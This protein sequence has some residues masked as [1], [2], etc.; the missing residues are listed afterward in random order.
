MK[1]QEKIGHEGV[2][3]VRK[4]IRDEN[5]VINAKNVMLGYACFHVSKH[6][7]LN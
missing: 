2:L 1:L 4:T 3:C 6:I 5:L 7:I